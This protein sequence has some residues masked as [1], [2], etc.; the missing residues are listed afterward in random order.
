M[1]TK[2]RNP[3]ERSWLSSTRLVPRESRNRF[4]GPTIL[5]ANILESLEGYE[6]LVHWNRGKRMYP[7]P[8]P[9]H[10]A[11]V[12]YLHFVILPL[13]ISLVLPTSGGLP[14]AAALVETRKQELK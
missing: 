12:A 10:A 5:P 9:F 13:G 3:P 1:V 11:G 7:V 14:T 6:S 2:E 8:P 4:S